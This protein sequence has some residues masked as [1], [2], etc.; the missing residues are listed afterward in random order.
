MTEHSPGPRSTNRKDTMI[1]AKVTEDTASDGLRIQIANDTEHATYLSGFTRNAD[2]SVKP[3]RDTP[4]TYCGLLLHQDEARA[5]WEELTR[6]FA[7]HPTN[8]LD[9]ADLCCICGAS[10][11]QPDPDDQDPYTIRWDGL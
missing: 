1:R 8:P 5:V 9:E 2:V 3:G 4:D 6:Y 11:P 7:A 10:D